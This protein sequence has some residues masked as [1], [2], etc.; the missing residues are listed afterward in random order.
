MRTVILALVLL[1]L[2]L[3]P[4]G[5]VMVGIVLKLGLERSYE[6]YGPAFTIM[7]GLGLLP[8]LLAIA[9]LFDRQEQ[10][11]QPPAPWQ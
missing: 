11:K 5:L 8:V 10:R 7:A 1:L 4:V 2:L 6:I 9:F 3:A